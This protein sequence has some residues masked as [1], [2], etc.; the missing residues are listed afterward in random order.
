VPRALL[1]RTLLAS[2]HAQHHRMP[3]ADAASKN[4]NHMNGKRNRLG[5]EKE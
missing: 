3:T 1:L 5:I 4:I 2:P